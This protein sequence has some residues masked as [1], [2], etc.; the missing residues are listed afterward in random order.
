MAEDGN[1]AKKMA[2][3]MYEDVKAF[4]EDLDDQSSRHFYIIYHNYNLTQAAEMV[5]EDVSKAIKACGETNTDM[6]EELDSSFKAWDAELEPALKEA[7]ANTKNMIV[8]QDYAS[9]KEFDKLFKVIDETRELTNA[10][11]NKVP[12]TRRDACESLLETMDETQE[13]LLKL[14]RS[15]LTTKVMLEPKEEPKGDE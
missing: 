11:F 15:T 2:E 10:Q 5:R 8:A 7:K 3:K 6:K 14:L 12:V 4:A 9:K 13:N 1:P